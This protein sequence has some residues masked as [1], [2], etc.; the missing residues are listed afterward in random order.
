MQ[1]EELFEFLERCPSIPKP[2]QEISHIFEM[3][4]NP[5]DLDIDLL[6]EKISKVDR[7][8]ELMIKNL[9]TGYFRTNREITTIKEAIVY[10]GMQTVQ[11]LLTF[12]ITLQLF[13]EIS[14][15][16]K[17]V[18]SMNHYLK[19]VLGTS[20]ASSML[21][22]ELKIG[23]KYKLF[24]YGLI[25]DIGIAV[26]D[27]CVPDILD[28]ITKKLE[29]GIH[30]LIAERSLLGGVTHAEVGAWLCRKW[31]IRED[32]IDIV[33]FHHT[34]FISDKTTNELKLIHMAD[35]ISTMY[36]EKL[37]GVNLNHNLNKQIMN[38][39]NITDDH[40]KAIADKLPDEVDKLSYYFGFN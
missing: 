31:N 35:V 28:D 3:L 1:R 8:N 9:N 37:L 4:R 16:K 23:D 11:N 40:I 5:V 30:Q 29:K 6:V 39:L 15:S 24:S 2:S 34:P 13:S 22:S 36:Y 7:L 12:F 26:L 20:I 10:L 17:R 33:E 19:H 25:H 38:S 27:I 32:I 14:Q 21:S 18:F